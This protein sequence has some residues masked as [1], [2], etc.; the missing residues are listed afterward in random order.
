MDYSKVLVEVD[1]VLKHLSKSDLAESFISLP[2]IFRNILAIKSGNILHYYTI[3][4]RIG[5]SSFINL[6]PRPSK[7]RIFVMC[8][9]R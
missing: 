5:F 9:L 6:V 8:Y 1:E 4:Y 7:G 2:D 3:W